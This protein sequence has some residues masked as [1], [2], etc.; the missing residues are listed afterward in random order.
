MY[1]I[2]KNG[3]PSSAVNIARILRPYCTVFVFG[4]IDCRV[5]SQKFTPNSKEI[6]QKWVQDYVKEVCE[7][8]HRAGVKKAFVVTP[9]PAQGSEND[10]GPFPKKGG[11]ESRIQATSWLTDEIRSAVNQVGSKPYSLGLVD[12]GQLLG[13]PDRSLRIKFQSEDGVHVNIE[14]ASGVQASIESCIVDSK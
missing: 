1:G 6:P 4:E 12:L 8:S 9:V 13:A 5:H 11:L 14:G 10:D 2:A 3:F 7:F